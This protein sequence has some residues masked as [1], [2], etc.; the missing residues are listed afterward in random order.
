MDNKTKVK[1]AVVIGIVVLAVIFIFMVVFVKGNRTKTNPNI[2]RKGEEGYV[3]PTATNTNT[4]SSSTRSDENP[5]TVSGEE[6]PVSRQD[7][8]TDTISLGIQNGNL[9]KIGSDL[10]VTNVTF[11]GNE[12]LE[13]CYGDNKAF[14]AIDNGNGEVCVVQID[15]S[16]SDYP[17]KILIEG[18]YGTIHN[19][20]YY[21]GKLYFISGSSQLVE[22]S[23]EESFARG[24]TNVNETSSFAINQ[25]NNTMYVSYRPSGVNPGIYVLDFTANTFTQI[26]TLN[27]LAG[28]L[29]LNGKTLVIDVKDYGSLYL[30]NIEKNTVA[31]IGADNYLAS[32]RDQIAFYNNIVLYTNGSSIDLKNEDGNVYQDSWYVLNDNSIAS[33][34]M[35]DDTRIQLARYDENGK[36]GGNITRSVVINLSDGTT[37]EKSDTVYLD[38]IRIK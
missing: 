2:P 15:L 4:T 24:L 35:L 16:K 13:F 9:V 5:T 29:I 22:Y 25:E 33:I 38:V 6:T 27:D 23:I 36:A 14:V 37:T 30:Y 19:I 10:S 7:T 8:L 26:I 34:S 28:E 11:L 3:D 20:E 12:Y 21:E 17:E 32:A 1:V 31:G 18:G